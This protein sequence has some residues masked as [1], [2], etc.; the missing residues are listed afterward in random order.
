MEKIGVCPVCGRE[1]DEYNAIEQCSICL[2]CQNEQFKRIESANGTHIA[3]FICCAAYNIPCLP[4]CAPLNLAERDGERWTAYLE[5][6]SA[7]DRLYKGDM[8]RTFGD[9]V[10][11]IRRIFGRE[12][13]ESDFARYIANEQKRTAAL[14]GSP[15]QRA[16]WGSEPFGKDLE[17][18]AKLYDDLDRQYYLWLDRYRGN[19]SPQLENSIITICKYTAIKDHLLKSGDYQNAGKIDK[20]IDTLMSSEQMRKKDEKP[21]EQARIDSI[22]VNLEKAGFMESGKLKTRDEVVDIIIERM[23]CR[24][25]Y[26]QTIDAVDQAMFGIINTMRANADLMK[27][28]ELPE[29]LMVEDVN[30]EFAD[31]ESEQEKQNREYAGL[32]RLR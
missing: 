25:K 19:N 6:L 5:E 3:I 17:I 18:S 7:A 2:D 22:V 1:L 27:L 32:T 12:L 9:G 24:K 28:S 31:V 26:P 4:E 11:D 21:V 23:L 16:R 14:P 15:E 10:S 13:S 30:N 29:E 8:P 20:M